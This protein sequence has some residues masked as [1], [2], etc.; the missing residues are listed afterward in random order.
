MRTFSEKNPAQV[1]SRWAVVPGVLHCEQ[2]WGNGTTEYALDLIKAVVTGAS[3]AG[4][5]GEE[6]QRPYSLPIDKGVRLPMIHIADLVRGLYLLATADRSALSE[7]EAGYA[8]AG[9]SFTAEELIPVVCKN[10]EGLVDEKAKTVD[11]G[12]LNPDMDSFAR[13]WPDSIS[14][15]E[16]Q[17]DLGFVS[18]RGFEETIAEI[19]AAHRG[20]RG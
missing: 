16:A 3:T 10:L 15:A 1:D 2:D 9:F 4:S 20:R 6:T 8:M 12:P 19:V 13:L 18:E 5:A 17:R 11:F 7:P 14:P